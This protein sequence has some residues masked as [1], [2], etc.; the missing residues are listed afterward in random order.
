MTPP[1]PAG[2]GRSKSL[3]ATF[4]R[5]AG[6]MASQATEEEGK[7]VILTKGKGVH[8][9]LSPVSLTPYHANIVHRYLQIDGR[10]EVEAVSSS[11]CRILSKEWKVHGGGYYTVQ[12]WLHNLILHGKSTAF[13]KYELKLLAR[14]VG[15]VP[16]ALGLEA[17]TLE[18]R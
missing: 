9:V 17:Y 2:P 15:E 1:E 18:F 12:H 16:P 3:H 4:Y 14:L 6:R 11:G 5:D 10:G 8:L 13:G 7:F